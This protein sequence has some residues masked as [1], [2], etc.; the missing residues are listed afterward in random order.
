MKIQFDSTQSYQLE[1]IQSVIDVLEGQPISQGDFEVNFQT[2]NIGFSEKGIANILQISNE[3]IIENLKKVHAKNQILNT[4]IDHTNIKSLNIEMETG[5]GKTYT[6]LRTIYELNKQYNFKKFVIVVPS[7]AIKEG[8][9]KTLQITHEHFQMLYNSPAVEFVL[10]DRNHKGKLRNFAISNAIQI[11]VIN[12]DSFAK[13]NNVI[14]QVKEQGIK[15]IEYIQNVSPIVIIDEPQN[16][17]T[18]IRK[19]AIQNLNPLFTL[20]YSATHTEKYNFLYSLNPVQ[21]YDLGLVKQIEVQGVTSESD[22]NHPYIELKKITNIKNKTEALIEIFVKTL[23]G[24]QPK[25]VLI[26]AKSNLFDVS[27]RLEIYKDGFMVN[28]ISKKD[29][30]IIFHNNLVLKVGQSN[31]HLQDDIQKVQVEKTIKSHFEKLKELQSKGIKVLSLF[32][33][34]KVSNYRVYDEDGN[35][36]KGK[37]AVW[38]EEIFKQY[39]QKP[40]YKDLITFD[41]EQMHNG[42]FSADKKG[43]QK[44]EVWVDS[45]EKNTQKDD[46]TYTLIMKDKERLLDTNEP[47][48]FIFSHSALREGWDNP[49]I[50]Q[51]CTLNDTKSELKK[52][53]EIGRGLRLCVNSLG[54]RIQDKNINLLTIIANE[55]YDTFANA[56]QK[57]IQEETGLPFDKKRIKNKDEPKAKIKLNKELTADNY[58]LFFEIWEKI[59]QQTKYKVNFKTEDLIKLATDKIKQMPSIRQPV[60]ISHLAKIDITNQG[61]ISEVR[62]ESVSYAKKINYQI[63]NIYAHIQS[64]IELK[65]T[66]IFQILTTCE[67]LNEITINPQM[68][69]DNVVDCIRQSLQQLLVDGIKYETINGK[70]YDINLFHNEEIETYLDGLYEVKNKEK[71]IFNYVSVDSSTEENFAKD[72]EKDEK[73]KFFFKIPKGFKIPTPLG[74]YTP[75][76]AII[77]END[78]KI[79][80]VAETKSTL[81]HNELR[82]SETQKIACGKAHFELFEEV[83]YK[84][85]T[86]KMDLY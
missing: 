30:E 65:K 19:Q 33:I 26:D 6:F 84:Q 16:F 71:T 46:D 58:P 12:I 4:K 38:F 15:P 13:D 34:D 49:N 64:K 27:G 37:F 86:K 70:K 9:L 10:Y 11:L 72:C 29:N 53:Q 59:N 56:L 41:V 40:Q 51:I 5:T 83:T 47:L 1:A 85:V 22:F 78:K 60:I 42:Y 67:R 63:P 44:K 80:F 28:N 7:V 75:D 8:A 76:W 31:L 18:E 21:A 25:S 74:Y 23:T 52:R 35:A 77:L 55:S 62:E 45:K 73:I 36:E 79:Y 17:D 24:I 69:L 81:N 48:Q 20:R 54:E 57:E 32:F 39:Q 43:K 50:F 61:V 66:T 14:N 68:F 3:Q 2:D 82:G